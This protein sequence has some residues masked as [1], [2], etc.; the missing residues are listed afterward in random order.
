M[1]AEHVSQLEGVSPFSN[2]MELKDWQ[3]LRVV[4]NTGDWWPELPAA[5]TDVIKKSD[6]RGL[7]QLREMELSRKEL[8]SGNSLCS[9]KSSLPQTL[10]F[11][12]FGE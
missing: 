5:V 6:W 11:M 3:L 1:C 12:R 8:S 2:L 10:D 7:G 9:P 4:N